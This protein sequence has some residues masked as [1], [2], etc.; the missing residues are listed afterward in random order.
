MFS[1]TNLSGTNETNEITANMTEYNVSA[2][3]SPGPA[4]AAGIRSPGRGHL[5]REEGRRTNVG[6]V[7]EDGKGARAQ[8]IYVS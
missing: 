3:K 4:G 5:Q 8:A 1:G 2:N 7:D 6:S